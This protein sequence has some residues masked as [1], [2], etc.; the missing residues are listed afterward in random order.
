M[1]T[2][3]YLQKCDVL[4]GKVELVAS[5]VNRHRY[6]LLPFTNQH[7]FMLNSG[8]YWATNPFFLSLAYARADLLY[9][10]LEI[11]LS[12]LISEFI[13]DKFFD[14]YIYK[15][16]FARMWRISQVHLQECDVFFAGMWRIIHH[17]WFKFAGM[18]RIY[19]PHGHPKCR[20][21]FSKNDP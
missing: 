9:C 17:Q 18:W 14:K 15:V 1:P 6:F 5:M 4:S 3:T 16:K 11:Y 21:D 19:E 2:H 20:I 10:Q 12:M 7:Y 8:I 13:K